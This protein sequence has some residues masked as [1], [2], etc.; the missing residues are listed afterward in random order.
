MPRAVAAGRPGGAT[1]GRS[2]R[3]AARRGGRLAAPA[4]GLTRRTARAIRREWAKRYSSCVA[5][6]RSSRRASSHFRC[7]PPPRTR[8]PPAL[9]HTLSR[10][11]ATDSPSLIRCGRGGGRC[12]AAWSPSRR[13]H[14]VA[15]PRRAVRL[16]SPP[17]APP[18]PPSH[19]HQ[20]HHHPRLRSRA[21]LAGTG[22]D[23]LA[24]AA[25]DCFR[26]F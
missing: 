21:P 15:P 12:G 9:A 8:A 23:E 17:P 10:A 2:G 5:A 6:A 24:E 26:M 16:A 13:R 11:T 4:C 7:T 3:L 19:H 25:W 1:S 22:R 20:H 14:S 18:P